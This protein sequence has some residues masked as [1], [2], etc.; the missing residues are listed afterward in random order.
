MIA[1]TTIEI[2]IS[3]FELT[4]SPIFKRD[5]VKT[6]KG[7]TAKLSCIER[8]I[9]LKTSYCVTLFSPM[10]A[11]TRNAGTTA[12]K[13]VSKRRCQGFKRN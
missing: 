11:I 10:K 9:W 6:T 5:E 8:M 12:I 3:A 1:A 4:K 13:R 7:I 2:T